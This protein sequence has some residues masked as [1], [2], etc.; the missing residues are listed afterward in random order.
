MKA[1]DVKR[2]K[3]KSQLSKDYEAYCSTADADASSWVL[4][5]DIVPNVAA[6]CTGACVYCSACLS[7]CWHEVH[8]SL[9]NILEKPVIE[10]DV[11]HDPEL[12][13]MVE[14]FLFGKRLTMNLC[15]EQ[16]IRYV[17]DFSEFGFL[18]E[19]TLLMP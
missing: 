2:E 8:N 18:N 12:L 19:N 17:P 15:R 9:R 7:M 3:G 13:A 14:S 4:P 10:W 6:F 1:E 11:H 16:R 5:Y